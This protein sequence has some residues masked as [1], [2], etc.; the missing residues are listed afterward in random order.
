M[1]THKED[2]M[3]ENMKSLAHSR[4]ECKYHGG[5]VPNIVARRSTEV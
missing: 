2:G 4:G 1:R 3:S 5:F